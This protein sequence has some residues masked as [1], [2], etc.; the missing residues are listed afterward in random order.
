MFTLAPE[1]PG[2]DRTVM[3]V[4]P[5]TLNPVEPQAVAPN[6]THEAEAPVKPVPVIVTLVPPDEG[7]LVV[8]TAVT[9]G[10]LELVNCRVNCCVAVPSSGVAAPCEQMIV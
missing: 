9:V 4:S 3:E 8:E 5:V 1:V 10:V 7:P 6:C 2:G